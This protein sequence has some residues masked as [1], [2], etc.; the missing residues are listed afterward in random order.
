VFAEIL[1]ESEQAPLKALPAGTTHLSAFLYARLPQAWAHLRGYSGYRLECGLRSS[2]V[3][4]FVG[5]PTLGFHLESY[6][7]QGAY[8]QAA[9]LLF[10]F[11]LLIASLRLWVRPRLLWVYAAASAV[12]LYSPVPVIWANVSRFLTQDIVP[13]PLRAEG[14]GTPDA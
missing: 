1:E 4:G 7:A 13:S 6:F 12:L 14:L 5:L 10:L 8:S 9:A 2:A 3:L 11:Y